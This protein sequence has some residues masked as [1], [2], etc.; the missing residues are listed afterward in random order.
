MAFG[1]PIVTTRWRSMPEML[2][3][4][5]P[6]LVDPQSPEQ[7]AAALIRLMNEKIRRKR[8]ATHFF[9]RFTLERHLDDLAEAIHSVENI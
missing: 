1:L 9:R 7:I 3:P 6:G 5:Y 8:C 4:D 2:P